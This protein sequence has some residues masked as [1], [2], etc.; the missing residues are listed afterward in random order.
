MNYY[1]ETLKKNLD[2]ENY[3]PFLKRLEIPLKDFSD[4][5]FLS[6]VLNTSSINSVYSKLLGIGQ[7]STP[8][9]DD[10]F[11]G[12]ITAMSIMNPEVEQKLF[13]LA[14]LRY[15][16]FTTK[17]SSILIRKILR[18]NFP[19]EIL[20]L[21]QLMRSNTQTIELEN[22]IRKVKEIG[23]SSGI[24]FLVGLFWQLRY[25]ENLK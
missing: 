6:E 8:Q 16:T 4:Q 19:Q 25:C 17:K 15:E 14:A 7:G 20:R 11:L 12:V 13:H 18:G 23:A 21:I 9:S 24:Y 10:V 22:E 5:I 3:Q 2:K 1:L